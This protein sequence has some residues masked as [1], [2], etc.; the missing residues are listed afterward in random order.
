LLPT[1]TWI[2]NLSFFDNLLTFLA[3][4]LSLVATFVTFSAAFTELTVLAFELSAFVADFELVTDF[5]RF[6]DVF[7]SVSVV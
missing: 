6:F 2:K 3:A 7:P 1:P 5:P 4:S